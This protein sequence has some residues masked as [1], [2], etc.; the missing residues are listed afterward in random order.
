MESSDMKAGSAVHSPVWFWTTLTVNLQYEITA[1][2]RYVMPTPIITI[3]YCATRISKLNVGYKLIYALTVTELLWFEIWLHKQ[4]IKITSSK[5]GLQ[6]EG[7]A[8]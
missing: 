8:N 7:Q 1:L 4:R 6:A 2:R 3:I 5:R